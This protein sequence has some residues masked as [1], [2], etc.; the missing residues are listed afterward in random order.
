M[1]EELETALSQLIQ[2]TLS[3]MDAAVGFG[4]EQ[5]PDVIQQLIV[6]N[7]WAAALWLLL[8]ATGTA[9]MSKLFY[10]CWKE[11]EADGAIFAAIPLIIFTLCMVGNALDLLKITLAPKVWLLEYAAN[12]IN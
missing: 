11:N 8:C 1:N 7:T 4:Q 5:L 2:K 9:L 3:G 10:Y 6:F 12:L